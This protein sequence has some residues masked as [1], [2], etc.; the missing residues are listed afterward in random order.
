MFCLENANN[1]YLGRNRKHTSSRANESPTQRLW[2][3]ATSRFTAGTETTPNIKG[4]IKKGINN[5]SCVQ[6]WKWGHFSARK[7]ASS[8]QWHWHQ[9]HHASYHSSALYMNL[10]GRKS[11]VQICK[12]LFLSFFSSLHSLIRH[13]KHNTTER[14]YAE[15]IIGNGLMTS[16]ET[17]VVILRRYFCATLSLMGQFLT[18]PLFHGLLVLL[19]STAH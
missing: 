5:I 18:F 19:S 16:E 17:D 13:Q 11:H 15:F 8:L 7:H 1:G 2:S 14:I 9:T 12:L 10:S 4:S 3:S 6:G